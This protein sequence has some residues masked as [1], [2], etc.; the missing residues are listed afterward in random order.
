MARSSRPLPAHTTTTTIITTPPLPSSLSSPP[1]SSPPSLAPQKKR[2]SSYIPFFRRQRSNTSPDADIELQQTEQPRP[3]SFKKLLR[4]LR[5]IILLLAF[6]TLILDAITISFE[7]N[8][9]SLDL[10]DVSTQAGLLLAP[11]ILAMVMILVLLIYPIIKKSNNK[12]E[13]VYVEEP[14]DYSDEEYYDYEDEEEEDQVRHGNPDHDRSVERLEAQRATLHRIEEALTLELGTGTRNEHQRQHHPRH[15]RVSPV[16]ERPENENDST[17]QEDEKA[18]VAQETAVETTTALAS[19]VTPSISPSLEKRRRRR[20]QY[21]HITLRFVAS[22]GIA[23]LALYWPASNLKPPMGYLPGLD[24]Y[25]HRHPTPSSTSREPTPTQMASPSPTLTSNSIIYGALDVNVPVVSSPRYGNNH[26]ENNNGNSGSWN[27]NGNGGGD[28]GPGN[29]GHHGNYGNRWCALEEAFGDNQSAIV[30]CQVKTVRPAMTY[31]WAILVIVEL[32]IA[33][34]AGDFSSQSEDEEQVQPEQPQ[35]LE[36]QQQQQQQQ[37]ERHE[38][39]EDMDEEGHTRFHMHSQ[40]RIS[41]QQQQLQRDREE[42]AAGGMGESSPSRPSTRRQR[43]E[44]SNR[45]RGRAVH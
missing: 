14:Y 40:D 13:D 38:Y 12:V 33:Y 20:K 41:S 37:S 27:G 34:M 45:R 16:A 44:G 10:S 5:L 19:E 4:S 26:G 31:V 39:I 7:V 43:S 30:Y 6:A 21:T 15:G 2:L 36:D 3:F 29:G 35:D 9:M 24:N 18:Q 17:Q 32:C 42:E 28:G 8:V 1:P 23:V 25:H 22:F 11:D